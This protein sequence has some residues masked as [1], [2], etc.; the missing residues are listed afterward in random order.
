MRPYTCT[1]S[2]IIDRRVSSVFSS[3]SWTVHVCDTCDKKE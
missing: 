1:E 3:L 2:I